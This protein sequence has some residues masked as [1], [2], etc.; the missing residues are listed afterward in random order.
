MVPGR[1][2]QLVAFATGFVLLTETGEVFTW[3]DARHERCLGRPVDVSVE[4]QTAE[5]HI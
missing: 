1:A 3:G 4:R 2:K 5:N